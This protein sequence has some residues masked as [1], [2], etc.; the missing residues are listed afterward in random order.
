MKIE[1]TRK[2]AI[3]FSDISVSEWGKKSNFFFTESPNGKSRRFPNTKLHT[4][5]YSNFSY[6]DSINYI[7][8]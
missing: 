5:R 6:L 4:Q 1:S 2:I 3:I 8:T 7:K